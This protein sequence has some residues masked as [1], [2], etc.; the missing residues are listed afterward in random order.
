MLSILLLPICF[1]YPFRLVAIE[2][3]QDNMSLSPKEL[4]KRIQVVIPK[5]AGYSS[6]EIDSSYFMT[7]NAVLNIRFFFKRPDEYALYI[8]DG[9]DSTPVFIVTQEHSLLYD[10]MK[11]HILHKRNKGLIFKVGHNLEKDQ[12]ILEAAFRHLTEESKP[13]IKNTVIVDLPSILN[14]MTIDLKAEKIARNE[15]LLSGFTKNQGYGAAHIN[16]TAVIPLTRMM[17]YP[18]GQRT[19]VF[20]FNKIE[21]ETTINDGIF[22]FPLTRLNS[23]GIPVKEMEIHEIESANIL[24]EAKAI[25]MAI[26]AI[27][28]RSAIRHPELRRETA[29]RIQ[30]NDWLSITKRDE[31]VS[32]LLRKLFPIK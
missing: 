23:S 27:F 4:K 14:Q 9:F 31:K 25:F 24:Q 15:F 32:S 26:E 5:K 1:L 28:I 22:K 21:T 17:I 20:A 29:Q 18:K 30:D 10:P 19:P 2:P 11:D 12:F 3:L 8:L 6:L 13:F 7:P 16:T